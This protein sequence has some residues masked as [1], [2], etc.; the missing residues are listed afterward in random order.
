MMIA[1][2]KT[3]KPIEYDVSFKYICQNCGGSHWLFL[4]EVQTKGFKIVCDCLEIFQPATISGI[5]IIYETDRAKPLEQKSELS[6]STIESCAKS[7]AKLGY[8][9]DECKEMIIKS[10]EA[11][12]TDDAKAIIE[13]SLS[14][15]GGQYV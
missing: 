3:Q 13:Y 11:I 10:F 14:N 6:V 5:D 15:F 7:L 8:E 1:K 9:I 4:R 12:G 2:E